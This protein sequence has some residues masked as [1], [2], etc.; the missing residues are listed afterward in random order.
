MPDPDALAEMIGS[1]RDCFSG[2][3]SRLADDLPNLFH[4]LRGS[5]LI[6]AMHTAPTQVQTP[7]VGAMIDFL[8]SMRSPLQGVDASGSLSDPWAASGLRRDEVRNASVLRWFLDPHAGHG[9]ADPLLTDLLEQANKIAPSDFPSRPSSACNVSVEEC[10]DGDRASRVDI[11]V[12]DPKFFLVIEVK[13][14]A[15]EQ[16][17]QIARYC[18]IAAGRATVMRPWAV[19]FLTLSGRTPSTAGNWADRVISISWKQLARSLRK[20][21]RDMAPVP[22]FLASSFATHISNF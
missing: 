19:I 15:Q 13:L 9:C 16:P 5:S 21:A 11:Q 8:D 22:R 1:L 10:P 7:A 14:D 6:G 2:P 17:G 12:N 4:A 20:A 18:E 3:S